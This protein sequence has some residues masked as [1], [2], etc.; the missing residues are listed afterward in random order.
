MDNS[1]DIQQYKN[2]P[3]DLFNYL[4]KVKIDNR[5]KDPEKL[6]NLIIELHNN[7]GIDIFKYAIKAIDKKFSCFDIN[8]IL[9]DS[10]PFLSLNLS[11]Y[12]DYLKVL[13]RCF[14]DDFAS[15]KQYELTNKLLQQ[16]SKIAKHLLNE[17]IP[18]GET[19]IVEHISIILTHL[20][21]NSYEET[22]NFINKHNTN[23][24]Q[25][26]ILALGN[27]ACK[28]SDLANDILE[29]LK[30]IALE[31]MDNMGEVVTISLLK[32]KHHGGDFKLQI[33]ELLKTN[34]SQIHFQV[35]RHLSFE[36]GFLSNEKW[37]EKFLMSFDKTS[38]EYRGIIDNLDRLLHDLIK[39]NKSLFK[40]FFTSWI[41]HSDYP[42]S[43]NELQDLFDSTFYVISTDKELVQELIT[44]YFNHDNRLVNQAGAELILFC[45]R[46]KTS[47]IEFDSDI[48]KTLSF[49]DILY[50]CRKILG[51]LID[52]EIFCSLSY[53]VL[54]ARIRNKRIVG[55]ITDIFINHIGY[56]Y[57]STTLDFLN[58]KISNKDVS[59]SLRIALQF[60]I[61]ELNK[62]REIYDSLP[63]LNELQPP[64]QQVYQGELACSKYMNKLMGENQEGSLSS[65]F[66][67]VYL[68]YG[69]GSCSYRSGNY[70]EISYMN[71][72]S[73][74]VEIPRAQVVHPVSLE[75]ENFHFRLAKRGE[76]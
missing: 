63:R 65:L 60:I 30:K 37:F 51:Y 44:N 76:N 47:N 41:V 71:Y 21:K 68:K 26:A 4:N 40:Q 19:F 49:D 11:S 32:M 58:K 3:L 33:L 35:S 74:S 5:K 52:V 43:K 64:K 48:L 57:P 34:N 72:I 55:T 14:N 66:S 73:H 53:S 61:D 7:Q 22:I 20:Y 16:Q 59:K 75:L 9:T 28:S 10:I 69:T 39:T 45:N 29:L 6:K 36:C 15:Y 46:S 12:C 27:F 13:F 8:D 67:K 38:C 54:G 23:T 56:N 1:L 50:I 70:S 31:D 17:L 62:N 24:T 42:Q 25:G 2:N 18:R